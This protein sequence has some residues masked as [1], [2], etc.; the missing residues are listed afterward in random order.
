MVATEFIQTIKANVDIALKKTGNADNLP[1]AYTNYEAL[2]SN[3]LLTIA[4]Q[5]LEGVDKTKALPDSSTLIFEVNADGTVQGYLN[6]VEYTPMGC[7]ASMPCQ[8]DTFT[9]AILALL[10]HNDVEAACVGETP[11]DLDRSIQN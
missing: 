3:T 2:S 9:S 1:L 4:T 8:A 11:S 7:S 6:D 10:A 5:T